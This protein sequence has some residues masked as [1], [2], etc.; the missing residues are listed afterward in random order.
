MMSKNSKP[1][2]LSRMV[3][4]SKFKARLEIQEM[5]DA[6]DPFIQL[7]EEANMDQE[8]LFNYYCSLCGALTLITNITLDKLP[9]RA[10]D[11]S[12]IIFTQYM[13]G[14]QVDLL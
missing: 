3:E 7:Q 5:K 9:L 12:L 2:R 1:K 10:T 6:N 11:K 13:L 8:T 4:V 14:H